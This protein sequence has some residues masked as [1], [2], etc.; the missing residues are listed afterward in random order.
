M[1][2]FYRKTGVKY[3]NSYFKL[4]NDPEMFFSHPGSIPGISTLRPAK[5][6]ATRGTATNNSKKGKLNNRK[7]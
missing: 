7:S 6:G 1:T 5:G 4:V 2:N 3:K